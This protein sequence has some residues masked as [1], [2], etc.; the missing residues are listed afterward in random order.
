MSQADVR[1]HRLA[2]KEFREARAWYDRRREG[3]GLEFRV[4]VDR[5]VD[6]IREHPDRWPVFR[7]RFRR[8]RIKRFPYLLYYHVL[9]SSNIVILAVAHRRRRSAYWIKRVS[10]S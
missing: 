4:E 7:D 3:L 10:S 1:F 6:R 8:V 2:A 9:D 5:T